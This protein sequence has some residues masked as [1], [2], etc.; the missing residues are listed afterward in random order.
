MTTIKN[1]VWIFDL[2]DTLHDATAHIFPEMHQLM[3]NYIMEKLHLSSDN[4]EKLRMHYWKIYG[5]TLKGLVLHHQ[6]DPHHFLRATHHFPDLPNMVVQS[7][8]LRIVIKSLPGRKVIFTN[9]QRD[10]ALAVL[11]IMGIADCFEL[12]F[13][14]E[15]V[16]FYAKPS[17]RGFQMLLRTLKANPR[18]CI[19]V[20]DSLPALMTAKRLGMRT[21]W[22][23]KKLQKPNFVDYRL[24]EALALTHL[25]L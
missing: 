8:R 23:T 17:F 7:E 14:V 2:D 5:A 19:M 4:A 16:K 12:V 22:I 1:K 10:Y 18:D 20:E 13:S 21:V 25:K 11:D 6:I 3:V 9:G 15:S 24:S